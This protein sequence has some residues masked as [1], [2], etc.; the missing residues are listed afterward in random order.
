MLEAFVW[1]I[2]LEAI[3]LIGLPFA[4]L[5][6]RRLPDRGWSLSKPFGLLLVSYLFWLVVLSRTVPNSR[7]TLLAVVVA[8]AA[9]SALLFSLHRQELAAFVRREVRLILLA[10][11]VTV[12]FFV[13]WTALRAQIP[14]IFH[15]EQPMDFAFLNAVVRS[16]SYPPLD[17]WLSGHVVSYYYF[18]YLMMG[19]LT[20][21]SG[22]GTSVGYNLGL[23]TVAA[24]A[25]VAAFGL[26]YNLVRMRKGSFAAAVMAGL[27]SVVMLL[28]LSNL[29]GALELLHARGLGSAGFWGVVGVEG[30]AAPGGASPSWASQESWWWWR[31]SRV[32]PGTIAEFPFFSLLLGDLHPHVMSLPFVLLALGVVL[33]AYATHRRLGL[34]WLQE[35]PWEA[36]ALALILG[37]LAFIN[38]WDFPT[39]AAVLVAALGLRA[40]HQSRG[41]LREAAGRA[42]LVTATILAAAVVAFL[43]FYGTFQSQA[44]GI[45]PLSGAASRPLHLFLVWGLL[46]FLGVSFLVVQYGTVPAHRSWRRALAMAGVV[47]LL[48]VV[49]WLL[50]RAL[51]IAPGGGASPVGGRLVLVV[52]FVFLVGGAVFSATVR[53]CAGRLGPTAFALVLA[54]VAFLLILGPELFFLVDLFNSRMNTVFKLYYQAWTFLAVASG[55]GLYYVA[56][57]LDHSDL[58][59]RPW[60]LAW[61]S[62]VAVLVAASLY[63]PAAAIYSRVKEDS[64]KATLDGLSHVARFSPWEYSAIQ[65][66]QANAPR[67]SVV[68]EAV[69]DD[70]SDFGRISAS[71][72][73]PTVLGWEGHELQWRGSELPF[74]GRRADVKELYTTQDVEQ[75][76]KLVRRYGVKYVVVGPRERRQYGSEG[77]AKFGGLGELVFQPADGVAIY[78]VSE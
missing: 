73:L 74:R 43:P 56:G 32:I 51:G 36:A 9:V 31:A 50:A 60:G 2:A 58:F 57:R 12:V 47:A 10:E 66:L 46:G 76:G 62:V 53:A 39:L 8:V 14:A 29:E 67:G 23:G 78:Q 52:P 59:R 20:M 18:G 61:W 72:G 1:L 6:F 28:L 38:L 30:L 27:A 45:L 68:L 26:V 54:A 70:Y 15:T 35:H 5:L 42:A 24:L 4:F 37:S 48:P 3:G 64:G 75:A 41:R 13:G 7:W 22:V 71:T 49:L 11:V 69:G 16:P 33:N 65:W 17:P 55:Y 63:Y 25:S 77:M 19:V 34:G 21:L 40:C 44:S